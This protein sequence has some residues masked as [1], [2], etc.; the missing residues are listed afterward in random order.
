MPMPV[1]SKDDEGGGG[2]APETVREERER[3]AGERAGHS[4]KG[5]GTYFCFMITV[6]PG[7]T[8][9]SYARGGGVPGPITPAHGGWGALHHPAAGRNSEAKWCGAFG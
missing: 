4:A 3:C 2:P 8:A 1:A 7:V 9:T 5:P 6:A